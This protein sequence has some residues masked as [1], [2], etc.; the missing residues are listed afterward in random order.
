VLQAYKSK[1]SL[2]RTGLTILVLLC[3]SKLPRATHHSAAEAHEWAIEQSQVNMFYDHIYLHTIQVSEK[4]N[5]IILMNTKIFKKKS[6]SRFV[7]L[8]HLS[9]HNLG[10]PGL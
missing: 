10:S 9:D 2:L 5:V 6:T 4:Y 7:N 3:H 8:I 1:P